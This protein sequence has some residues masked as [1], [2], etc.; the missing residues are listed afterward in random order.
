[1]KHFKSFASKSARD[2]KHIQVSV[3]APH[4]SQVFE[5]ESLLYICIQGMHTSRFFQMRY[6]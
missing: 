5:K 4:Q 6:C 3:F 2:L 1:M